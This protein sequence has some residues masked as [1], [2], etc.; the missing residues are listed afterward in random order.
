MRYL[1]YDCGDAADACEKGL[2]WASRVLPLV[3]LS[4]GPSASNNH[5]WPEIYT[6]L[7]LIEGAGQRAYGFDM[8]GPIRFGNA[9]TFDTALFATPREYAELLLAGKEPHRYT[10]LDVADWLDRMADGCEQE[11]LNARRS[12]NFGSPAVQRIVTDVLICG[13]LARFFAEKF[14]ASCWAELFIA[15]TVSDLIE[16]VLDHARRAVMAWQGIADISRDLYHDDLS[17]GPQSW[18]RGSWHS[19]LPEIRAEILDLES[20]R[21]G[22]RHESVQP[23]DEA[24]AAINA[25]ANRQ[26]VLAEK[27]KLDAPSAF[28]AG[29]P[30]VLHL[31][32]VVDVEPTLHYRHINQAERWRSIVMTRQGD[33]YAAS[34]PADYTDSKFHLQYFVSATRNGRAVLSPGMDEN[35]ANEPYYTALQA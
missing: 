29:K 23:A 10:P 5:Y 1:N 28:T 3:S 13:G 14:R 22:G 19:R 18:L 27:M 20:L 25:L 2:S 4:H 11:V 21:G 15:T 9:P 7:P 30:L 35:L 33:G 16:P 32:G 6:N 26:P 12:S 34:I 8:D 17:Y 24:K 31:G